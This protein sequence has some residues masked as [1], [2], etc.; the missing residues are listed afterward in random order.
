MFC[1]FCGTEVAEGTVFCPNCGNSMGANN[2]TPNSSDSSSTGSL[3]AAGKKL[4]IIIGAAVVAA[5]AFII[6]IVSLV[7]A[8]SYKA[9]IKKQFKLINSKCTDTEKFMAYNCPKFEIKYQKD[10]SKIIKDTMDKSDWEDYSEK[11]DYFVVQNSQLEDIYDM[12]EDG[13]GKNWKV[14]YEIR[15]VKELKNS[16]LK[17]KLERIESQADYYDKKADN[18][19]A[20]D[21][22]LENLEDEYDAKTSGVAKKLENLYREYSKQL[23]DA[24]VTKGYK[25]NLKIKIEGKDGKDT[26]K[27]T[28]YVYKINGKWVADDI[29]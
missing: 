9:A 22:L 3:P 16:D 4:P 17:D 8:N 13:Y 27:T 10:Y 14:S 28:V 7:N 21:S 5:L 12:F 29:F 23:D 2:N 18:D 24:T 19:D 25:V 11:N 20:I 1:G 15:D 26:N 6:I